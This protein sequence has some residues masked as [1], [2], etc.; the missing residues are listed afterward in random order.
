MGLLDVL[1]SPK[2]ADV[3]TS[4]GAA[5]AGSR[6]PV[7]GYA[8]LQ[9]MEKR[10]KMRAFAEQL[11][12]AGLDPSDPKSWTLGAL[13]TASQSGVLSPE[14]LINAG[15]ALWGTSLKEEDLGETVR[16]HNIQKDLGEK[17][18]DLDREKLKIERVKALAALQAAM[19]KGDDQ[20]KDAVTAIKN[21]VG[22]LY[23]SAL[24][25]PVLTETQA[26][27]LQRNYYADLQKA[28][29]LFDKSPDKTMEAAA[30]VINE[31]LSERI[32]LNAYEKFVNGEAEKI[33][34]KGKAYYKVITDYNRVI[35]LPEE[36]LIEKGFIKPEEK[37][38]EEKKEVKKGLLDRIIP[39]Q[40]KLNLGDYHLFGGFDG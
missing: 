12:N 10:Q 40:K 6:D 19:H 5:A 38:K 15:A 11:K 8:M 16:W 13:R 4:I 27:E 9:E 36:D 14:Q 34:Y 20:T 31:V 30:R 2:L 3:A 29:D 1:T 21:W 17:G 24:G 33:D 32:K 39:K 35:L 22:D 18:L 7:Q 37:K 25:S 28:V 26:L 23:K